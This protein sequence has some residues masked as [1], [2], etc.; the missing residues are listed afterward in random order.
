MSKST[1]I[2]VG[3][4]AV[5]VA[6]VAVLGSLRHTDEP[7]TAPTAVVPTKPTP[8]TASSSAGSEHADA[9]AAV[10]AQL[11][12]AAPE[13]KITAQTNDQTF[14]VNDSG[15]LVLDQQTRLN[16]EALF[17]RTPRD[18]LA[19]ARQ[20]AVEPLPAGAAAQATDL[21]EDYDNYQQAQRQAYPPGVAPATE[22]AALAELEGLHALRAA[23][24]GAVIAR[25][26][27]GEEEI[28]AR[29][30]IELMRLEKDQSLTMEEKA[31]RAEQIERRNREDPH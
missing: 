30:L 7:R 3:V 18:H 13:E 6:G 4:A 1:V 27:Y 11:D 28:V 22:E 26:L 21:L 8:A 15:R 17:A 19:E 31:A 23:H 24:F 5:A 14:R 10:P 16:M 12:A 29:Q 20:Q 25:A 9:V 2:W